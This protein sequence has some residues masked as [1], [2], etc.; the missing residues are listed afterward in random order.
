MKVGRHDFDLTKLRP[1]TLGDMEAL[2]DIGVNLKDLEGMS[3]KMLTKFV[4]YFA[5]KAQPNITEDDVR[6]LATAD[7]KFL[8]EKLN[9]EPDKDFLAS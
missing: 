8:M 7:L 2:E 3:A 1:M 5:S 6:E 4:T 9:E